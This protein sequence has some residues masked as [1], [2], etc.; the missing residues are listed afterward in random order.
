VTA[1]DDTAGIAI[2][3]MACRLP[4]A[5]SPAALW[6]NLCAGVD[7]ITFFS[8]ADLL[9]AGISPALLTNPAY[10]KAGAILR[11][12]DKFDAAFFGF[13][14]RE[15]TLLDPQQRL[16]LEVSWEAFEDAGYHPE[17]YEGVAG[18]FA[19]GGGVVTSYLLAHAGHPAFDTATASMAHLG[20]DKDFL[21]TRV[22]Y[23]L[24]LTGPSLT[25][26][27]A[28]S[29]SLVAVHLAAQSLLAGEC[30]MALAA[31]TTVRIPQVAGYL[32]EKGNVYS[33]DGRCRAF[34]ASGQGTI[35]GSGVAAVL[36]KKVA[37]AVA[38]S[39]HIY[40]VIKG[41]AVN[42]DGGRKLSFPSPS[43]AGQSRAMVEAL[44][45]AD[46]P[47]DTVRYVECHATGT[48]VG[49][50]QE[51]QALTRAFRAS[52]SR[53][54]FCALG[55][56]KTNIGHPEQ[57]A[58]LAGLIKAAL[59]LFHGRI[60]PSLHFVTPNPKIDFAGGPFYVNTTLADWPQ[61]PHPRRA[62]VNSLGI[63]GTNAF[64]VL[65][66]APAPP[67]APPP[68]LAVLTL[69]AKSEDALRAHVERTAAF[70]AG[71]PAGSLADLCYTSNL[72]RSQLPYRLAVPARTVAHLHEALS[73]ALSGEVP[74]PMVNARG[75]EP[76]LAML[77]SGQ[78]AQYAGMAAA[79]YR[80]HPVFREALGR[81]AAALEG[82]LPRPLLDVLMANGGDPVALDDT[83]YTQPALVAVEIALADAWS[84]WGV[85]PAAVLGHSVGEFAAAYVAGCVSREDALRLVAE[86]GRLM[87]SLPRDGAMVAVLATEEIVRDAMGAASGRVAVAAVNAPE[88]VVLSGARHDVD[89]VLGRLES[90]GIESR[91][92]RV[93]HA[94]HSPLVEPILDRF[95]AAAA[96]IQWQSP[97]I[98][99]VSNVTGQVLAGV[100]GASYWRAHAR[101]TVRF[102]EGVRTL[103]GLG[104]TAFMELG[105]GSTLVNLARQGAPP[106]RGVWV[107]TL[108]R[109]GSEWGA[110]AE[111]LAQLYLCGQSI[112]WR[113][114]HRGT[115]AR[116]I[117]MPTY[118]FQR[119]RFW[120]EPI[121]APTVADVPPALEPTARHSVHPLLG[122][123]TVSGGS[124]TFEAK[125]SLARFPY[126][127]EHRIAGA[128]VL[129]TTAIVEAALA[130]A[131][132]HFGSAPLAIDDF[133]YHEVARLP[134]SGEQPVR[135]VLKPVAPDR[136]NWS[137]AA[138]AGDGTWRVHAR[139]VA[140]VVAADADQVAPDPRPR[141]PRA[142]TPE[143]F[144]ADLSAI[145]LEYGPS[146]RG[147]VELGLGRSAAM[148]RVRLPSPLVG[149]G[150]A[151]HPAFLDACLHLFPALL[152]GS[153]RAGGGTYL[154]VGIERLRVHRDGAVDARVIA[155]LRKPAPAQDGHVVDVRVLDDDERP[156]ATVEGLSVR[157]LAAA[158]LG[159]DDIVPQGAPALY[160]VR[161]EARPR[162]T[163]GEPATAEPGVW[164]VFAGAGGLGSG[165]AAALRRRDQTCHLV[166]AGRAFARVGQQTWRLD[167]RQPAHFRRLL[168]EVSSADPRVVRGC[169]LAWAADA[170]PRRRPLT[171]SELDRAQTRDAGAALFLSQALIDA[172]STT[173][174]GARLWLVTRNAQLCGRTDHATAV[175]QSIL[176]GLGRTMALETPA[177]WG[178]LVDLPAAVHPSDDADGLVSEL[179]EPDGETQVA[180]RGGVRH[181]AR[182]ARVGR[183]GARGPA[184]R[185]RPDATYL[186]TGGLGMLGL[187]T[188]RQLVES[189][190]VRSIVLVS[191]RRPT[192]AARAEI[193]ALRARGARIHVRSADIGT[194]RGVGH[195]MAALR[196]RPPLRGVFHGAGVIDDG[197]LAR[198][199]WS[200]FIRVTAAKVR[201]AWLLHRHTARHPL[202]VFV[203]HSSQ[204]SVTGSAG[205]ANYTAANAFLDALADHRRALG[206][207]ATALNWGPWAESG[208]ASST[209]ARGAAM[210]KARGVRH[211]DPAAAMRAFQ[212]VLR[213]GL[214]HAM[215]A[216]V[217]WTTFLGHL[218]PAATRFYANLSVATGTDGPRPVGGADDARACARLRTASPAER[219]GL[220]LDLVRRLVMAEL[221]FTEA[222]DPTQPLN[223]LGLDSLMSVNVANRLET[224]LEAPV[225][226]AKL[227]RGPS[228]ERLVDDLMVD[229]D[230]PVAGGA[231]PVEDIAA[232]ATTDGDAWLVVPR[233]RP[234]AALRLFCFPFAGA[235]AG[236][237]RPWA[238]ALH[239]SIELVAVEPPGRASR[240]HEPP[241]RDLERF[242]GRLTAALEPRLDRPA[243]FF[244][245][246]LGG[247]IAWEAARRLRQRGRLDLRAFIV[248][249]V[250]PPSRLAHE[251]HF[252][253]S[254]LERML[255]HESF[256]PL[257]PAH[258][259]PD[260]VFAEITRHFNIDATD[261]FLARPELKRL[262][263]PT[264][265][266]DFALTAAYRYRP[267]PPWD[268]PIICFSG[269]E[270]P[271]VS[272]EDAR[273]W[274]DFTCRSFSLHWRA[275]A[276][277]LVVEDREFIVAT[278][279]RELIG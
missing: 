161:W 151:L 187:R 113:L 41:T 131:R 167:P 88:S 152:P 54:A 17:S 262:L 231:V 223:E 188:A 239:P 23:K 236:P 13:S 127:A 25:V 208:M 198:M 180:L 89:L 136:A 248:A 72:S 101:E 18:V 193:A 202:D 98:P 266:A 240:I 210:W 75:A 183:A 255:E 211:L 189:E 219:R 76:R 43:V 14:P 49:D 256:D 195:V 158:T 117:S 119:R 132:I 94:F 150:Y 221:G 133:V 85:Q 224:V 106:D 34:D 129:P 63:G 134:D 254:L 60:P 179:L 276:H 278:L 116:R 31:A 257:R 15:A 270:D 253:H 80:E 222:I 78:G 146:F 79:L 237:Y 20:N 51:V 30:D 148:S 83:R 50:P 2:V 138:A 71:E 190:G 32:A 67:T 37:T 53:S 8:D 235:G 126:L 196:R 143:R 73:R 91:P 39:D 121:A 6:R 5:E 153:A 197:V 59:S 172:R 258:E 234:A 22:S 215:V 175:A 232:P 122:P 186:I 111:A 24:N 159:E 3:G 118:P 259:Q 139:G 74:L 194:T 141:C 181:V 206:L 227:I 84:A 56:I 216:D 154:P 147:I 108:P 229:L 61:D 144:Y 246:C 105:P 81:C 184:A 201:G 93:S 204:L 233:P 245:H 58:G 38:D 104:M 209:G 64:A 103:R 260:E 207:P 27:T 247:L 92:L 170:P 125:W 4:G 124:R 115:S 252:E 26:Q 191:R 142:V 36:L 242:F 213:G 90:A 65:E 250:R 46:C 1:P 185:F 264:V 9:A 66:E 279:N 130:A 29:T 169:V 164:L 212:E 162:S 273:A 277:F 55:S 48:S 52:T 12:A 225:P 173:G 157:R 217:D 182:L 205:Q 10:V 45:L 160:D 16:L 241:E 97:R 77:C 19:G 268:V 220:L 114:V 107:A 33:L 249:G 135:L 228:V 178:G 174:T 35:F 203:L 128:A 269:L 95:E 99:L 251:G 11:D 171:L 192:P 47:P 96:Q 243:A 137:L 7:S 263:L 109:A 40:A 86:R 226:L 87:A 267:E 123:V 272:R 120:L 261:E 102:A 110:M 176:W 214:S 163:V 199:T 70:L 62:G 265:R 57:A 69:S 28:C 165:V 271:Y 42:N 230:G 156:I 68:P 145:G 82:H 177:L 218:P 166:S 238:D 155:T 200:Q 275:G 244:G 100:P 168:R 44:T 112:D 149:A 21:A 140:S 274:T